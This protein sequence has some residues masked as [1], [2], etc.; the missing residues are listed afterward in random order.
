MSGNDIIEVTDADFDTEVLQS[1]LPVLVDFW[2]EWCAPCR[3]V[4]P[5]IE[6]LARERR[7]ELK[8]VKLNVD[9]GGATAARYGV[10]SIPTVILFRDGEAVARVVGALP[11]ESLV[12]E[13]GL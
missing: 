6:E 4:A 9:A 8:V 2:A 10:M 12:Q 1:D 3:M 13:L 5:A 11:K 7:G